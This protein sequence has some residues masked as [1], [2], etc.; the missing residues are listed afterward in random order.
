MNATLQINGQIAMNNSRGNVLFLIL[1]AVA[2]FAALSYA[3]TSSTRSSSQNSSQE[4]E[5]AQAAAIIQYLASLDAGLMRM[6]IGNGIPLENISFEYQVQLHNGTKLTQFQNANCT[7]DSCRLFKPT[8]GNVIPLDFRPYANLNPTGIGA[9]WIAPGYFIFVM[10]ESPGIGTNKND[11]A[12]RME[13][14]KPGLCEKIN[15]R[16]GVG[17][18]VYMT[19]SNGHPEDPA[20]W[21]N[22]AMGV[23]SYSQ[24]FVNGINTYSSEIYYPGT[25][26]SYC[27]LHH[28]LVER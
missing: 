3:V 2:L 19:G 16:L 13:Y 8:G 17:G 21:D 1:I 14:L 25:P 5:T 12:I 23:D 26:G 4:T 7:S 22:P 20:Q 15:E 11:I 10:L 9:N 18:T 28:I 6:R 27:Y 24:P